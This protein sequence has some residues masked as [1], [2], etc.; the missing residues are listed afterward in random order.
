MPNIP[1]TLEPAMTTINLD[2]LDRSILRHLQL[3]GRM[4]NLDLSRAVGLSPATIATFLPAIEAG[5][6]DALAERPPT[7]G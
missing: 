1:L 4:S 6:L 2:D 5:L 3:D 7:D